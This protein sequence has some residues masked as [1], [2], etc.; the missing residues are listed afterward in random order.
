[1]W[2]LKLV[3]RILVKAFRIVPHLSLIVRRKRRFLILDPFLTS[4]V[5]HNLN[6]DLGF[7]TALESKGWSVT[8][9]ANRYAYDEVISEAKAHRLFASA[10]YVEFSPFFEAFQRRNGDFYRDLRLFNFAS[11]GADNV[12]LV[13]TI[14][15]FE[16]F[17][18]ARW[19]QELPKNKRPR[20]IVY[21]QMG[22]AFGLND[23]DEIGYALDAYRSVARAL[24]HIPGVV[25][26]SSSQRLSDLFPVGTIASSLFPLPIA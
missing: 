23:E 4:P 12:V 6:F 14:T 24:S 5:S 3:R 7:R 20:L 19:Y 2:I 8:I 1:M 26:C 9:L 17:G 21:V 11:F 10:G 18:L 16:L 22:A 13:H 15:V 25:L